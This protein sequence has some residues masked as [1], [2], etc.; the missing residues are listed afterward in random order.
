MP[1]GKREQTTWAGGIHCEQQ[2][3]QP[4]E[5]ESA[6]SPSSFVVRVRHTSFPLIPWWCEGGEGGDWG[7]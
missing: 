6:P 2:A 3:Q 5:V 4:F 7:T 1:T